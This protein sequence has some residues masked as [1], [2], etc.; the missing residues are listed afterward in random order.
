MSLNAAL[1]G[2]P[3]PLVDDGKRITAPWYNALIRIAKD[4]ASAIEALGSITGGT[5]Y[6]NGSYANV[7][8]IGGSGKEATANITVA[9]GSVTVVTI[10]DPGILYQVG[11]ILSAHASSIGGT[12][13]GFHVTVAT[14]N[15]LNIDLPGQPTPLVDDNKLI[16][17][18]WYNSILGLGVA[19]AAIGGLKAA[20]PGQSY[21]LVDENRRITEPWYNAL[22][23]I[24]NDLV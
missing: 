23:V 16:N 20:I 7:P 17:D 8:L 24:A 19:A 22:V 11:D 15:T 2:Q 13:S 4:A 5:L 12:G 21:P 3:Y 18:A 10:V 9:G 1:P 14:I 6:T